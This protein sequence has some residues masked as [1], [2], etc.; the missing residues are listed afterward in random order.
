MNANI[1]PTRL[2]ELSSDKLGLS[3]RGHSKL[4]SE[5]IGVHPIVATQLEFFQK[6]KTGCA[7]AAFAARNPVY[8]G[9]RHVVLS[10]TPS[11]IDTALDEAMGDESTTTISLIFPQIT[12]IAELQNF[13]DDVI[14][15]CSTLWI[16]QDQEW[17][18]R[19]CVGIRGKVSGCSSWVTGFGPFT[20]L[21]NTRR[22]PFTELALRVKPRPHFKFVMKAAQAGTIHLA[23]MDLLGISECC[24]RR[25]W[26]A[27]TYRVKRLLGAPADLKSAA[28]TTFAL[29]VQ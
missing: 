17:D 18:D 7:F 21:P 13:V 8:Y 16:E 2:V 24:F 10:A 12:S 4:H 6:N 11:D 23:D 1:Q 26:D 25:M 9:W 20:C 5:A 14:G 15:K 29:P 27:S 28:K 3:P 19:R 22:A